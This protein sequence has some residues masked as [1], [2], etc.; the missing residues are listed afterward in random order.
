MLA[1]VIVRAADGL[2]AGSDL[3]KGPQDA[4]AFLAEGRSGVHRAPPLAVVVED[5]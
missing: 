4:S 2:Q 3:R 1:P 5:A